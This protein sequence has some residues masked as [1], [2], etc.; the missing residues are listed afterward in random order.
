MKTYS[1]Y[2]AV[3]RDG[4]IGLC[5]IVTTFKAFLFCWFIVC[6]LTL[7]NSTNA[8]A[9]FTCAD[10]CSQGYVQLDLSSSA[11]SLCFSLPTGRESKVCMELDMTFA[12]G[13]GCEDTAHV[14]VALYKFSS[15][16]FAA[17][18]TCT[19]P[20]HYQFIAR[21]DY[22]TGSCP[23]GS[24]V[25]C[26]CLPPGNYYIKVL[27]WGV[28]YAKCFTGHIKVCLDCNSSNCP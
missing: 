12:T 27:S 11:D 6:V 4:H 26:C 8:K 24:N 2:R 7:F 18:D 25:Q 15:G 1:M 22:Y 17:P 20:L 10:F 21:D 3:G 23:N 28:N 13:I 5:K 19:S 14:D 9:Q 16:G